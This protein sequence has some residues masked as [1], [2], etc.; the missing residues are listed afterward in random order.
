M[1]AG[2]QREI[3][4]TS[5][6]KTA[7]IQR[8]PLTCLQNVDPSKQSAVEE[9][10]WDIRQAYVTELDAAKAGV[11]ESQIEKAARRRHEEMTQFIAWLQDPMPRI[12]GAAAP[13][14]QHSVQLHSA[15]DDLLRADGISIGQYRQA[16]EE[17]LTAVRAFD[18]I[19]TKLLASIENS[20]ANGQFEAPSM[21]TL[22]DKYLLSL[23]HLLLGILGDEGTGSKDL[24]VYLVMELEDGDLRR[25]SDEYS[26]RKSLARR[27]TEVVKPPKGV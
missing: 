7:K 26:Y 23:H 9:G 12:E 13:A 18:R 5:M 19:H 27:I 6:A 8:R 15:I 24:I 1:M 20:L 16:A 21:K 14:G 3:F 22:R 10:A 2:R 4:G 17:A 25:T 11:S